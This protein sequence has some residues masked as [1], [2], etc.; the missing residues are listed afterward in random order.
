MLFFSKQQEQAAECAN[1][2]LEKIF[3]RKEV[4]QS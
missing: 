4:P 2:I 3:F 1:M